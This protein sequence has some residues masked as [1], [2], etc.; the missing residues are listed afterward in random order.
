MKITKRLVLGIGLLLISLV[1]ATTI[2]ISLCG[3]PDFSGQLS[4]KILNDITRLNPIEVESVIVPKSVADIVAAVTSSVSS[5]SI[6]GGRYSQGG[7]TATERSLHLDMRQFDQVVDLRPKQK[8]VT[9]QA[10]ITWRKLQTAIDPEQLSVRIMQTYSNF[11][12]GGTLSVNAHGRYIGDGPVIA[13]VVSFTIV[14]ADGTVKR[15]SRTQNP[16]LFYGAIGGYGGLGVIAEVTLSLAP[17]VKVERRATKITLADYPKYFKKNIEKNPKVIFHNVDIYLTDCAQGLDVS[18][19]ESDQ[20]LTDKSALKP[21]NLESTWHA[22]LIDLVA[23]LSF[24]DW[25]R[26]HIIDPIYYFPDQV[27]WRNW[28]ASYDV[29]ELDSKKESEDTYVLQ[30]YFVPVAQF[31]QFLPKMCKTFREAKVNVVNVS[32]RHAKADSGSYLSWAPTD[33][34]AFVVYYRQ[35]MDLDAKKSVGKWTRKLID[36]ILAHGGAYYLPYQPHATVKQFHLAYPGAQKFFALK[37][38]VDPQGRFQ[39]KLWNRYYPSLEQSVRQYLSQVENYQKGIEQ[40]FLTIP[41]WY[42]VFQPEEYANYLKQGQHPSDFP[43]WE[44]INEYWVL[45]DRVSHLVKGVYP[46]N[47]EYQTMLWVIGVSTTLEFLMK[48]AYENTLGRLAAG[49]SGY[50]TDEDK[51]AY[52]AQAAYVKLIYDEPWYKFDY[53]S[54]IKNMWSQTDFFGPH[55]VRK[56]ERKL[57]F[58]LEYSLKSLYARLIQY[59]AESSYGVSSGQVV[60]WVRSPVDLPAVDSRVRVLQKFDEGHQVIELPRWGDF[61]EILPKLLAAQVQIVEI[62]GNHQIVMTVISPD[63][64]AKDLGPARLLFS[65]K[66]MFPTSHQRQAYLIQVH[67]LGAVLENVITEGLRLEHFYDY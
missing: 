45:H 42:L 9:V 6:G 13:S 11:T 5:I 37:A 25:L 65:S 52:K 62:A 10:G 64:T 56:L 35:K 29:S 48:G 63:K 55:F 50:D 15:A 8:Q 59:G 7:Q 27:V 20:D 61:S 47:A 22:D 32:I 24:G 46:S 53:G 23:D 49:I 17:N 26:E 60:M 66:V 3:D 40:T 4:D 14:L 43:F 19:F 1:L 18:W 41:E 31:S 28:E 34:F 44:S 36:Q 16:E 2:T 57:S 33:V 30:E 12:V 54:W 58:T 51:L 39:N 67:D 21:I 38:E